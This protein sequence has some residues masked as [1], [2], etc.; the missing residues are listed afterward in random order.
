MPALI[1]GGARGRPGEIS[2][3]HRGVLFLDEWPEFPRPALEALRQPMET[4]RT[5]ISR[6]HAHVTYPA[7]FQCV[8][9]MNPC[10]C[11]YLGEAGRECGRAPRCG[12]D[13]QGRL[14][15][16]L[17]DR[18]DLTIEVMPIPAAELARAPAG[19]TSVTVAARVQAARDAQRARWGADGPASNAE[20]GIEALMPLL[21]A[22]AAALMETAATRLRLSSRGH[23]RTLRVACS[24]A[25]LAG[26]ATIRRAHV[27]EALAFRHRMPGRAAA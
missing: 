16:P 17:L 3:A 21:D 5:V 14:S 6:V 2:L 23:V 13:Y 4:G 10:R 15:G 18:M 1:G 8:A 7:R 25:D 9:A 12:E 24:I 20:A 22:D 27:A 11:G 19:E 26:S